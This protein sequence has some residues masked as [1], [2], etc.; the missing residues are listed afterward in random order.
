MG[1][2]S[3]TPANLVARL[4]VLIGIIGSGLGVI[5]SLRGATDL[6]LKVC[7]GSLGIGVVVLLLGTIFVTLANATIEEE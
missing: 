7:L 4:I 2:E 1:A 5:F 6:A 3:P